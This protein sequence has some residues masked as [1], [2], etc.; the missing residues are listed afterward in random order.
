M[1]QSPSSIHP[2][3]DQEPAQ[4][5]APSSEH[6]TCSACSATASRDLTRGGCGIPRG[7]EHFNALACL[8][9]VRL[10]GPRPP[11]VTARPVCG[12]CVLTAVTAAL[13][14]LASLGQ[15]CTAGTVA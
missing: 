7:W 15:Q 13:D 14:A 8:A 4:A 9:C 5:S 2:S 3:R 11:A 10:S 1:A 6:F 12:A